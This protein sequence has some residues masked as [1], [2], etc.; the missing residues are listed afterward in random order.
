M[1]YYKKLTC[2][3]HLIVEISKYILLVAMK[4]RSDVLLENGKGPSREGWI[5]VLL[6][7]KS[8]NFCRTWPWES[9]ANRTIDS[10][11][12]FSSVGP[13]DRS[14]VYA[15]LRPTVWNFVLPVLEHV[16]QFR[17][18]CKKIA[19]YEKRRKALSYT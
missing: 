10:P 9:T 6:R 7:K 18:S 16:S 3:L 19:A 12:H 4:I 14:Y 5:G 11:T 8:I 1:I 2:V 17:L 13:E 15:I